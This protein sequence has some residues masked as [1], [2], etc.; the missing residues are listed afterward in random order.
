M[1]TKLMALI[2]ALAMLLGTSSFAAPSAVLIESAVEMQEV[3]TVDLQAEIRG[4]RRLLP[5]SRIA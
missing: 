5:R 4:G 3:E 1:K 2:M